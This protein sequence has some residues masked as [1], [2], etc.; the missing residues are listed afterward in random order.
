MCLVYSTLHILAIGV[1]LSL[2]KDDHY[3]KPLLGL[4]SNSTISRTPFNLSRFLEPGPCVSWTNSYKW[5][6]EI[7]P[8][9]YKNN[10]AKLN[11]YFLY[12]Y[13]LILSISS[14]RI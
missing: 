1:V 4:W 12:Y 8:G 13:R 7:V 2:F 9:N 11:F 14:N 6:K 10:Y 3:L 5:L